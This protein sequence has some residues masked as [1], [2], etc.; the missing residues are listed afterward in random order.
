MSRAQHGRRPDPATL[1][2][3][4]GIAAFLAITLGPSL[5]GLQVFAGL[6]LL[7]LFL[8]YSRAFPLEEPVASIFVRDTLDSL[9]PAYSEFRRRLFNGD[10]AFWLPWSAGGAPLAALP[11]YAL[12]SPLSLPYWLL[13]TWLAPA[14]TQLLTILTGIA[15][16]R[17]MQTGQPV[18]VADLVRL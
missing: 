9:L 15:A 5:L 3:A 11:S 16:N 8:P 2:A 10:L 4:V 6:D 18:R 13:P 14:V 7:R 12:F 1:F 17:A